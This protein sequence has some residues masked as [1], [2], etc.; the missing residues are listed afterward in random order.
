MPYQPRHAAPSRLVIPGATHTVRFWTLPIVI[1]VALMTA[2]AALYLGG[3]LNPTEITIGI[4]RSPW[5]MATPVPAE[6]RSSTD[7]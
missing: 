6:H 2:L 3:I 5:S 7:W 1:S 4:S